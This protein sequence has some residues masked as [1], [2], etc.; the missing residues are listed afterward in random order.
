MDSSPLLK[1]GDLSSS[2]DSVSWVKSMTLESA[3][4]WGVPS[5][6]LLVV[7]SSVDFKLS[8]SCEKERLLYF[9]LWLKFLNCEFA[10]FCGFVIVF[11]KSVLV[12]IWV[13]KFLVV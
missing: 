3:V 11:P 13:F 2:I 10:F 1:L 7:G 4:K 12:L 9:E 5:T 6:I 8:S